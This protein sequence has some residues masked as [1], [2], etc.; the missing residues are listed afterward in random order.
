MWVMTTIADSRSTPVATQLQGVASQAAQIPPLEQNMQSLMNDV[1]TLKAHDGYNSAEIYRVSSLAEKNAGNVGQLTTDFEKSFSSN[2]AT[3]TEIE[4]QFRASDQSRNV[5][6]ANQQ[7]TNALL[8][9]K[10][11]G[12]SYPSEIQYYP[13]IARPDGK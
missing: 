10:S 11:Y 4:T 2:Q 13:E 5:Q 9:R 3:F 8:W 7:R 6:F 1:S 12:E